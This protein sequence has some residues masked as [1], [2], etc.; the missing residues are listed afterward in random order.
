[1]INITRL[2]T[3]AEQPA[4]HLRYGHGSGHGRA[5]GGAADSCAPA[6]S[7][8]RKPIVVWNIT[9][10]CN[11]RCVHCYADAAAQQF[12]GE[13]T[14]DQCCSVIDDLATYK[15]NA[16][17]F[18]G[19]EPMVHPRFLDL[20]RYATSKGLKITISTNGT[21]ITP[22]IATKLKEMNVAYVGISLDGIGAVH[23]QF[24]GVKGCFDQAVNGFRLCSEVGQ[25]T[26]LRLTLTRNNVQCMEQI[27]DFIDAQDIQRTCFYHL[28]PTG[29]GVEVQTL[30]PD[31]ARAAMD[32]LIR[33][34]ELWREQGKIRE[35]LTVTQPVD[36]IYL[37]L[38]QLREKSPLAV[39]TLRLLQWNGGGANSSGRGIA[40]IDT[41]GLVHPDQF[42]QS[43]TLGCVK[44]DLFSDIWE[45]KSGAA[46]DLLPELR[47]SD[48]PLERQ[49]NI[50]GRCHTCKH[51]ALCGGG[52]RTRAA[53]AN[54]NWYG[55]DPGCYLTDE[56]IETPLPDWLFKEAA[57]IHTCLK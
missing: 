1:M 41:Q 19:G 4:D 9:R 57:Q 52:F 44:D 49:K 39:D 2:W 34:V 17:L 22:E 54:G 46:V 18:S 7:R 38:R 25:K 51:F 8:A 27:L 30:H 31:E 15:V 23:D 37:L 20:V 13:L 45:A 28:V 40:N 14:W 11:L 16:L 53:F 36:G 12:P 33:R 48:D 24:R 43:V 21:R 29:R 26:G 50:T 55:S 47:A 5:A 6:S 3:G 10:T 35:V 42:W 56:E 32:S